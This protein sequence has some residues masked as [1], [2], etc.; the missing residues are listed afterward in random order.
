MDDV[1]CSHDLFIGRRHELERMARGV[2][3][4]VERGCGG[5]ETNADECQQRPYTAMARI[6][7]YLSMYPVLS[8]AS[9]ANFILNCTEEAD[10][11]L[12]AIYEAGEQNKFLELFHQL[13]DLYNL[14]ERT[15]FH[16]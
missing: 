3:G 16:D 7:A 2:E 11:S 1:N 14:Y 9:Y 13:E 10:K 4:G 5:W 8:A 15:N 12:D 6:A